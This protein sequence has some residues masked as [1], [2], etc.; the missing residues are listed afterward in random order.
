MCITCG[1]NV[2]TCNAEGVA[3]TCSNDYQL[4]ASNQCE[5]GDG[6]Y[7]LNS[8]C[9]T[10]GPNVATCNAEGVAQTCSNDYQLN[11]SNQCECGDGNYVNSGGTCTTC[12]ANVATCADTTG[13]AQTC[14]EDYYIVSTSPGTST[15]TQKPCTSTDSS[16][17]LSN[18]A[19]CFNCNALGVDPGENYEKNGQVYEHESTFSMS[20]ESS[21]TYVQGTDTYNFQIAGLSCRMG[22]RPTA[23]CSRD[24]SY[25]LDGCFNCEECGEGEYATGCT[26]DTETDCVSCTHGG[27]CLGCVAANADTPI[28]D[29]GD[30]N[31]SPSGSHFTS[32]G[33]ACV[34]TLPCVQ[35]WKGTDC[36]TECTHGEACESCPSEQ[37]WD[38]GTEENNF[39]TIGGSGTCVTRQTMECIQGYTGT[40][41]TTQCTHGEVCPGCEAANTGTPIWDTG[42][43][44]LDR[45]LA[46]RGGGPSCVDQP[47][48]CIA[49]YE[50]N[51]DGDCVIC[52]Q[53]MF[54]QSGGQCQGCPPGT[55]TSEAGQERCIDKH[56]CYEN[57]D[58]LCGCS[59]GGCENTYL[60]DY[61]GNDTVGSCTPDIC[62]GSDYIKKDWQEA[63]NFNDVDVAFF[64]TGPAS[65][66]VNTGVQSNLRLGGIEDNPFYR[67]PTLQG[68]TCT[69]LKNEI[70]AGDT[71]SFEVPAGQ[72]QQFLDDVRDCGPNYSYKIVS[73]METI[74]IDIDDNGDLTKEIFYD[75]C[76]NANDKCTDFQCEQDTHLIDSP[77][78]IS[79][80]SLDCS[81]DDDQ[82]ICCESNQTCSEWY[83][84]NACPEN[85]HSSGL[86]SCQ[87]DDGL[88]SLSECCDND[89]CIRPSN[90]SGYVII[91]QSTL[92]KDGFSVDAECDSDYYG[93]ATVETCSTHDSEYILSGCSPKICRRPEN[94]DGYEITE[95][96]LTKDGF[97]VTFICSD[98]FQMDGD[99]PATPASPGSSPSGSDDS[100]DS[101]I[102]TYQADA[103]NNHDEEY[104]LSG[105]KPIVCDNLDSLVIDC[106]TDAPCSSWENCYILDADGLPD[107]TH[108]GSCSSADAKKLAPEIYKAKLK[109]DPTDED[110]IPLTGDIYENG[111]WY[112]DYNE[113]I[114]TCEIKPTLECRQGDSCAN[115][116]CHTNG[117][118]L[119]LNP[120]LIE[121]SGDQT[122]TDELCCQESPATCGDWAGSSSLESKCESELGG[123]PGTVDVLETTTRL[124]TSGGTGNVTGIGSEKDTCCSAITGKCAGNTDA[125]EDI[126]G[127]ICQSVNKTYNPS[128]FHGGN[129]IENCCGVITGKCSGNTDSQEDITCPPGKNVR[130]IDIPV[131]DE[132]QTEVE[133]CCEILQC[134]VNQKVVNHA[135]VDCPES[136]TNKSIGDDASGDDTECNVNCSGNWSDTCGDDESPPCIRTFTISTAKQGQGLDC[137][138]AGEVIT[139][140]QVENCPDGSPCLNNL[141]IDSQIVTTCD[142]Y[143]N[144]CNDS[145]QTTQSLLDYL[146]IDGTAAIDNFNTICPDDENGVPAPDPTVCSG[147]TNMEGFQNDY[148]IEG[149]EEVNVPIQLRITP[150]N[151][152]ENISRSEIN[153]RLNEGVEIPNLGISFIKNIQKKQIKEKKEKGLYKIFGYIIGVVILVSILLYAI[154][155]FK[156]QKS[157]LA[158]LLT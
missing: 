119:K 85:T 56:K 68:K 23:I 13:N 4:N 61:C 131:L 53:N 50:K 128:A 136:A 150:N 66:L 111:N 47:L 41:C 20:D 158:D 121:I 57:Y 7:V 16:I 107:G 2:A 110:G 124:Y 137:M 80:S 154:Y 31:N 86:V 138:E 30:A 118:H 60:K 25:T 113:T 10:C 152:D 8:V 134:D 156:S 55:F 70:K 95:N 97:D 153:E 36:A 143:R 38:S 67:K 99:A 148:L 64:N 103:C 14:N 147:F 59:G 12:G 133:V 78:S 69:A 142:Q 62:C 81:S 116:P 130:S 65:S 19:A 22:G 3:Q 112:L 144:F 63:V 33:E 145:S 9:T 155:S 93:M 98:G 101:D 91:T 17:P 88:C 109:C 15:C 106:P 90:T 140:N 135:C 44:D 73:D 146:D 76:C 52:A 108:D 89:M 5:C 72:S 21:A 125:S 123:E 51:G 28:W 120:H 127:N 32:S 34:A 126:P 122:L 29:S 157:P 102:I 151:P 27:E 114:N 40:D 115:H 104:I 49:G 11:A 42:S 1:P 58:D 83:G 6:N 79:C 24:G 39:R 26:S 35:G 129:P 54:S 75:F 92:T 46:T 45:K 96:T 82:G 71:I 43:N 84:T 141:I 100:D 77:D 48:N 132:N 149:M 74:R 18:R 37:F 94:T 105:C 139:D 87:A 117:K